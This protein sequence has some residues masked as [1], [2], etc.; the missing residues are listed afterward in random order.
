MLQVQITI[1]AFAPPAAFASSAA[2]TAGLTF[3]PSFHRTR[4][5][6]ARLRRPSRERTR[7]TFTNNECQWS[8]LNS[9][10]LTMRVDSTRNAICD[11]DVELGNNIF[12][13]LR[14]QHESGWKEE[15]L[16]RVDTSLA[17]I[18]HGSTFNH[19]PHGKTFDGLVLSYTS[20]TVGAANKFN[21]AASLLVAT[22]ISSFLGLK[23]NKYLVQS[24]NI[25]NPIQASGPGLSDINR[26]WAWKNAERT[27]EC[28][29][30][31][32]NTPFCL[33]RSMC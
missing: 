15:L 30:Q 12:Y 26:I 23:K 5:G 28:N 7:T 20:R 8:R 14:T 22:A 17:D 13:I 11:F 6:G 1:Y 29:E 27:S 4:G 16:T 10:S 31:H 24:T 18:L 9:D 3:L 25:Q 21:V 33:E 19:V 32:K 2:A